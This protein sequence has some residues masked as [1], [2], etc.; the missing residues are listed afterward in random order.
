MKLDNKISLEQK[1][2]LSLAQLHALKILSLDNFELNQF[3][4]N[5]YTENPLMEYNVIS[6]LPQWNQ[7][8]G[9]QR[10]Q[11]PDE[12]FLNIPDRPQ[13]NIK[14]HLLDQL[15]KKDFTKLQWDTMSRMIDCL[16]DN[17]YFRLSAKE[18]SRWSGVPVDCARYCLGI[19]SELEPCG[20]FSRDLPHC[21]IYQLRRQHELTPLLNRIIR[22]H[23]DD[24]ASGKFSA[25]ARELSVST[26]EIKN[27]ITK[28]QS[29]NPRPVTGISPASSCYIVPDIIMTCN[30][31]Q[32]EIS[33]NDQW[34]ANYSLCDYYVNMIETIKDAELKTYFLQKYNR[35]N[36]IM[37]NIEQ[38]RNTILKI[39]RA[40]LE[41]QIDYF[42]FQAPLVPMTLSDIASDL[43]MH[44]STISRGIRNKYLQHP[45]GTICLKDLFVHNAGKNSATSSVAIKNRIQELINS[46]N[47][48]KP[49]SDS[50]LAD[51]LNK[52]DIHISRRT[53]SKY[54]EEL[55]I[56]NAY[57]R[58]L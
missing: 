8:S 17:G 48:N 42:T 14:E 39:T 20:I 23:L 5:E 57:L 13:Y 44:T 37:N 9:G 50:A 3:L 54:R 32:W 24:I 40:I 28:I 1:Q 26:H 33:L 41:R 52:E 25:L 29:L 51:L 47:R 49:Y 31:G 2:T 43:D 10:I 19:L 38:R 11:N 36:L 45:F 30:A 6:D 4:Q 53:V 21:L 55:G 58:K 15:N 12:F 56:K 34:I 46:E 16:D 27:C 7:Y 22:Y 35:Y 18:F